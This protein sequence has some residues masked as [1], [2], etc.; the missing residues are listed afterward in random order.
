MM[1]TLLR[2]SAFLALL[3]AAGCSSI[4]PAPA[5]VT[6]P[7]VETP[8]CPVCPGVESQQPQCPEP[9]VVEK[10]VTVPAPAPT[11]AKA[12]TAGKLNLPIVGAVEWAKVEPG[13]IRMQARIDTGA[14][15]TSIH[16]E[17]I[18]LV[19]KDGK[20]WMHFNLLD[21]ATKEKVA[22]EQRLRRK[23][24]SKQS[25][26]EEQHRYVVK[27]WVTLGESRS[28]V[29]VTLTDRDNMEYPLVIGRNLLVDT[30]IVDV[31]RKNQ[32]AQ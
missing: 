7:A 30:A 23:L 16:A 29:E 6:C 18:E 17:D 13:D 5:T 12:T 22:V 32:A 14:A 31:S 1:I 2:T 11:P 24:V 20:R 10:I 28:L 15:T 9:Q 26:G 8:S 25:D 19:E 21:P 3:L 4:K 27:L